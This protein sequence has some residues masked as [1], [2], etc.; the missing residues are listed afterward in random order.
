LINLWQ[1]KRFLGAVL[2]E[3]SVVDTHPS[4]VRVL[5]MDENGVGKPLRMENFADEAHHE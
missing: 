3:V 5:L 1:P 4:V 2:V